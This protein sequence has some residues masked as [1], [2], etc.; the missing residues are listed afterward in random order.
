MGAYDITRNAIIQMAR[1]RKQQPKEGAEHEEKA[2]RQLVA[3]NNRKI[4]EAQ[5]CR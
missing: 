2:R 4:N 1:K 5:L 3:E